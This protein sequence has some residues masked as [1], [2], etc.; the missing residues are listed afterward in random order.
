[1][2]DLSYT[3]GFRDLLVYQ[4]ARQLAK[5]IHTLSSA[6]TIRESPADFFWKELKTDN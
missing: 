4:K 3:I 5:E 6:I 2:T 1:M